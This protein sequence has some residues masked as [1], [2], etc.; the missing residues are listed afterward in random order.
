[1]RTKYRYTQARNN[2]TDKPKI[3]AANSALGRKV[4][5]V[6]GMQCALRVADV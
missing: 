3:P 1:M 6:V 5:G 2:C 4:S